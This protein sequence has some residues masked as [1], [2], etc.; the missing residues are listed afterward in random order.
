MR[1][2]EWEWNVGAGDGK[3]EAV[4]RVTPRAVLRSISSSV[5]KAKSV[6]KDIRFSYRVDGFIIA[7]RP[8]GRVFPVREEYWSFA[9]LD[10]A[11]AVSN[12]VIDGFIDARA[13][14]SPSIVDGALQNGAV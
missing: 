6:H 9:P 14:S 13:A 11:E 8:A 7:Y 5:R 12:C 10:V 2:R 1:P 3:W 4:A